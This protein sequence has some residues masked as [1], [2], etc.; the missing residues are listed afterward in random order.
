MILYIHA[1]IGDIDI[2]CSYKMTVKSPVSREFVYRDN[3]LEITACPRKRE[4]RKIPTDMGS[5]FLANGS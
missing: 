4:P 2:I 5:L 1:I 3:A